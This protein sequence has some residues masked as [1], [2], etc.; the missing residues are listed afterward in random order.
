[1]NTR[2]EQVINRLYAIR[3]YQSLSRADVAAI[4]SAID[5]LEAIQG[6]AE[7]NCSINSIEG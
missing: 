4:E 1:M 5:A 6:I 7:G 2:L 3:A